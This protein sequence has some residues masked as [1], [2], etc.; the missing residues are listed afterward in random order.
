MA[1]N[2]SNKPKV[3]LVKIKMRTNYRDVAKS[4]EVYETDAEKAAEL[5][6]LGRAEAIEE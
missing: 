6:R 1:K 2:K 5:I 3:E 4:G